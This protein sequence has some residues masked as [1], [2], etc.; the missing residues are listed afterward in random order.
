MGQK[1]SLWRA[2]LVCGIGTLFF[3]NQFIQMSVSNALSPYLM[4]DFALSGTQWGH[5]SAAYFYGNVCFLLIA[6]IL[7]DRFSTKGTLLCVT[8]ISAVAAWFF[9]T[10]QSFEILLL[11]RVVIGLVGA[12]AFLTV[13]KLAIR[14][15][16][17]DRLALA[18]G[19][20]VTFA[21]AGGL[22]AQTPLVWLIDKM[23]DWRSAMLIDV[24]VGAA[25][26]LLILCLVQDYPKGAK[27][28]ETSSAKQSFGAALLAVVVN[29]HNWLGGLVVSLLNLPIFVFSG[30]GAMFLESAY[31]LD[32]ANASHV[33]SSMFLGFM[34]GSPIFG[35]LSD[36]FSFSWRHIKWLHQGSRKQ[37]L[38]VGAIVSIIT[39]IFLLSGLSLSKSELM[40]LF[41]IVGF[42]SGVQVIGYPYIAEHNPAHLSGTAGG[43]GSTLIMAGGFIHVLFGFLLGLS[44]EASEVAGVM[45]YTTHDFYTALLILP[46]AYVLSLICLAWMVE[47]H[48]KP[49]H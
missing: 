41:V 3:F 15:F 26:F 6:G 21:M 40:V 10:T 27:E 1:V 35:W 25:V 28:E 8:A 16:P 32:A 43:L 17:S 37:L 47:T 12:F 33:V 2:W 22:V 46:V 38:V 20:L 49:M 4:K 44:G 11:A 31:G 42:V 45:K 18:M 5:F 23:G 39:M 24:W 7:L 36:R 48:A 30:F 34:A 9:A 19:G 14:W 13:L 29:R